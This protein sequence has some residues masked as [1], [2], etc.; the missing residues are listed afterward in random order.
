[1]SFRTRLDG[2]P[3]PQVNADTRRSP[4]GE[5]GTPHV[6]ASGDAAN[7]ADY[8]PLL[9]RLNANEQRG[10]WLLW[11]GLAFLFPLPMW[12]GFGGLL[13]GVALWSA[14]LGL[15]GHLRGA[16]PVELTYELDSGQSKRYQALRN[17]VEALR[18]CSAVWQVQSF[19]YTDDW[20]RNAGAGQ[21]LQWQ[22]VNK[23]GGPDRRFRDNRQ[24]P[25][26]RYGKVAFQ[27]NSGLGAALVTSGTRAAAEF[28]EA[29]CLL[30][31]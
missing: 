10:Q 31:Q 29:L 3:T 16:S 13:A 5:E 14:C 8:A 2:G 1:L 4:A 23:N 11:T 22:Y 19:E 24:I 12:F 20:K 18:Q 21:L 27:S 6:I 25:I 28:A 7:M 30:R 9:E 17:G 15:R 26:A